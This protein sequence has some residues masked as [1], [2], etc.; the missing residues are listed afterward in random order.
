MTDID[1]D[2]I[3]DALD[4]LIDN[5]INAFQ[6]ILDKILEAVVDFGGNFIRGDLTANAP[7]LLCLVLVMLAS[8][9]ILGYKI[10]KG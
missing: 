9:G 7:A 10:S 2:I 1:S 6:T 5:F 3:E 8:G 4:T